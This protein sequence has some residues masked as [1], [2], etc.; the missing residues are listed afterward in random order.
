MTLL[1]AQSMTADLAE[2]GSEGGPEKRPGELR[3]ERLQ[4]REDESCVLAMDMVVNRLPIYGLWA[5]KAFKRMPRYRREYVK[6]YVSGAQ[7]MALHIAGKPI[8]KKITPPPV[9]VPKWVLRLQPRARWHHHPNGDGWVSSTATVSL[10]AYV[11]PKCAVYDNARVVEYAE[12]SGH[13][14]ACGDAEMYGVSKAGGHAVVGGSARVG[15]AIH[16]LADVRV[17]EGLLMG[18]GV[19]REQSQLARW[20][21]EPGAMPQ[22][23]R[24]T[25][26]QGTGISP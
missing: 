4:R 12:L 24:F 1:D 19:I 14:H 8:S 6:G 7:D 22:R 2:A 13:A 20:T 18:D 17:Y 25:M 15:G 16:L 11:G 10:T 3:M 5:S 9:R 23:R 21:L 26:L